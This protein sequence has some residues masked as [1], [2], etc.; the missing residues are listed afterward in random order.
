[1]KEK[2][3]EYRERIL[4]LSTELERLPEAKR[5]MEEM[6]QDMN[7]LIRQNHALRSRILKSS[8]KESRMS[9][10]LRDALYE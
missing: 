5:L 10:R 2:M 3:E 8:G 1:M 4:A 9:S 7:E 6:M